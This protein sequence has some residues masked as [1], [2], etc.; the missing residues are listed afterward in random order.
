MT[1]VWGTVTVALGAGTKVVVEMAKG[2]DLALD[3]QMEAGRR[4]DIW[5]APVWPLNIPDFRAPGAYGAVRRFDIH[6]GVDLYAAEGTPVCAVQ[7]G[8][9]IAVENF[10]G[11]SAGTPWW[12][13]TQAILI[14]G[15]S[16]VVV[17]GEITPAVQ[18]GDTVQAGQ[19]VGTIKQVL[20]QDKG[21]TPVCMLHLELLDHGATESAPV[22]ALGAPTPAG[23]LNPTEH[24][25]PA[26]SPLGQ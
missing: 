24:L 26:R 4:D 25:I 3:A 17:Y 1:M 6:T 22:W 21:V 16:G 12:L 15:A 5:V 19:V 20:R 23:L 14:A 7:A 13:D 10:T 2:T 11:P 9:I 8:T 18:V